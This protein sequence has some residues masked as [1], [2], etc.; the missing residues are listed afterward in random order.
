M[1]EKSNTATKPKRPV[2]HREAVERVHRA[3]SFAVEL[4]LVG[5]VPVPR[6][7]QLAYMGGLAALVALELIEWPV[8]V[9]VA[10]GHL[11][12]SSHHNKVLEELGEAFEAVEE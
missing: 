2:S 12:A 7:D 9:A 10:A 5:R 3:E 1:V 6:P 11:L 4:P 8:A